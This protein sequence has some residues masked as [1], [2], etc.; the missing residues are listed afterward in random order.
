MLRP[1]KGPGQAG[2][3]GPEES[4]GGSSE[5]VRLSDSRSTPAGGGGRGRE[6]IPDYILR[7]GSP[8]QA[9]STQK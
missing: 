5:E 2:E 6:N 7:S 3:G 8:L 9:D 4:R 1:R